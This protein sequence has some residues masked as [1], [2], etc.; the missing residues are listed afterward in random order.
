MKFFTEL[1]TF[2]C[3][4]RDNGNFE[5]GQ[6]WVKMRLLVGRMA[7]EYVLNRLKADVLSEV[8]QLENDPLIN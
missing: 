8:Y 6:Q 4:G 1:I 3:G 2:H 5:K 7:H